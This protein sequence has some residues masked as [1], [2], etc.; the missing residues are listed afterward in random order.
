M[1]NK[2]YKHPYVV[3]NKMIWYTVNNIVLP[4]VIYK[5]FGFYGMVYFVTI[6]LL[7]AL[8]LEVI[9]YVEHYGTYILIN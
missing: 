9:N 4:I 6:G 2:G 5:I 3:E 7:G 1:R 8:Y